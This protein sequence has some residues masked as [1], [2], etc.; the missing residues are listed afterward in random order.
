MIVVGRGRTIPGMQAKHF[1]IVRTLCAALSLW[2]LGGCG[3]NVGYVVK[4]V[5][6]DESLVETAILRDPGLFV[7]DKI[8][9]IDLDGLLLNA[10]DRGLLLMR[11]NPVSLFVE[12]MDKA[13]ADPSVRAVVVRINSPGG[14]V[15]ASDILYQ[16]VRD[17]RRARKGVPVVAMVEDLGASGGYYV[18]CGCD[19]ILAHPTSIVGSIGVIVQTVSFAGTMQK[20]GIDARAVTSGKYKDLASPLKPLREDDLQIVQGLVNDFYKRFVGVVEAGRPKLAADRIAALADGRVYT[21]AQAVENGL[22]DCVGYMSDA[23]ALAKK[24]SGARAVQVVMYDRPLGYRANAYSQAPVPPAAQVNLV[25]ITL[26]DLADLQQPQ[27]QYLWT[28]RN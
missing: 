8:V 16:R 25:N 18:A 21:G 4:P 24:R 10:R 2:A 13:Q 14:S 26:N 3:Q 19:T 15:T 5:P 7:S 6:L 17:F 9:V 27:F 28:G 20:L 1:T 11:E 22:V 23:L 12:K